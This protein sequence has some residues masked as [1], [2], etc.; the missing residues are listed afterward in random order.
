MKTWGSLAAFGLVCGALCMACSPTSSEARDV[1]AAQRADALELRPRCTDALESVYLKPERFASGGDS[2]GDVVRCAQGQT[3]QV[4]TLAA[5]LGRSGFD[6]RVKRA[7]RL[8]RISYRTQRFDGTPDLSSALVAL[9]VREGDDDEGAE[10][11]HD[12]FDREVESLMGG[13]GDWAVGLRY[14]HRDWDSDT[15]THDDDDADSD[16]ATDEE[17]D[18]G[19]DGRA[20]GDEFAGAPLI[21]YGHGTVPY[22]PSCAYSRSNPLTAQV[23]GAPDLELRS[24]LAL[25]AQGWPVIMPDYPG[26]VAHSTVAGYMFAADEAYALLDATHAMRKLLEQPPEK[27]VMVGHSQGG[28]GV[29]SAQAFASRYRPAGELSGVVAMAPFW[30]PARTFGLLLNPGAY[31]TDDF[32]EAYALS[33][34]VEYF[35]THAELREGEGSGRGIFDRS[36]VSDEDIDAVVQSCDFEPSIGNLGLTTDEFMNPAFLDSVLGCAAQGL[37]SPRLADSFRADRPALDPLGAPI[38]MW[39]G[40]MDAIIPSYI[41]GCGVDKI[42]QDLA[43]SGG[44]ATF[45][46]CADSA[47]DHETVESRNAAWVIAWIK[48]RTMGGPEP[49]G[50]GDE[51]ALHASCDFGNEDVL[52][53][54]VPSA[55]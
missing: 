8:L 6:V 15:D 12:D 14:A 2:R 51:E 38:L 22:G 40:A 35:Y 55:N 17:L 1:S 11:E 18:R 30:A 25:A 50:C 37:C 29:L 53:P 46:L 47:A 49:G 36:R 54:P 31:S 9:P 33:T 52:P 19:H 32:A 4:E 10:H 20:D 27:V 42:R 48:A 21:V 45:R 34:A 26:F 16:E 7:V 44:T 23:F 13:G 5:E 24:V 3:I 43:V 28:H 39:Q 41:V